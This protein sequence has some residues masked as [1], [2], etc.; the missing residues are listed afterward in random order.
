MGVSE[1]SNYSGYFPIIWICAGNTVKSCAEWD[2]REPVFAALSEIAASRRGW[3]PYRSTDGTTRSC[4][5][6]SV[7]HGLFIL[8]CSCETG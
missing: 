2:R 1:P 4:L 5:H 6:E 7:Q 8:T 3:G